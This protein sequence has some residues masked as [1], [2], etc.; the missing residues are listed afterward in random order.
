MNEQSYEYRT[1]QTQPEK[2]SRGLVAFLLICLIFLCGV[3]SGLGLMNVH[4][5]R[6]L[7]K[8][9][10]TAPISFQQGENL[11]AEGD[12]LSLTLEGMT[13]QELPVLYQQMYDLPQ[14]LYITQVARESKAKAAGVAPGDVL[15]SVD[16]MP[17]TQLDTL[18]TF[19]NTDQE[20]VVLTLH[21]EGETVSLTLGK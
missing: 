13:F 1:G 18:Q 10:A 7:E 5:F 4:L 14:G 21:R 12:T 15:I 3:V 9:I 17:V 16:G 2:S 6:R 8:S 20:Q 11:P 19:M